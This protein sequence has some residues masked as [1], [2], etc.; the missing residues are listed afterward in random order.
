[1]LRR[2][3]GQGTLVG[4][5]DRSS[6]DDCASAPSLAPSATATL[7]KRMSF[8]KSQRGVTLIELMVTLAVFAIG[9]AVAYPSFT[10]VIR[11]NRV[12]TSTNNFIGA[13]NLARSEAIRSN[14]GGAVCPSA[15]GEACFGT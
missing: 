6:R 2:P 10:S 7:G 14:R 4:L 5:D 8:C 9:A 11:S 3:S 15:D 1:M 13:F 12:A